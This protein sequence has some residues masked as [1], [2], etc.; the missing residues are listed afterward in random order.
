MAELTKVAGPPNAG[1]HAL[2]FHGLNGSTEATWKVA[3]GQGLW[4]SWFADEIEGLAVWAVGYSAAGSCWTGP[5]NM[6]LTELA[7]VLLQR[8]AHEKELEAGN[9][10]LVGY[11]LGGLVAKAVLRAAEDLKTDPYAGSLFQRVERVATIATPHFGS[12]WAGWQTR[13]SW[14]TR[15]TR[16]ARSLRLSDP[17]LVNLNRWFVNWAAGRADRTLAFREGLDHT[18]GRKIVA[19]ESANPGTVREIN[20][21]KD[22]TT[23]VHVADRTDIVYL[24]L[25]RFL[26]EMVASRLKVAPAS[27]QANEAR[28]E[29]LFGKLDENQTDVTRG[30]AQLRPSSSTASSQDAIA[31]IV[32]PP[33]P[34]G[35]VDAEIDRRLRR[36]RRGRFVPGYPREREARTLAEQLLRGELSGGGVSARRDALAWVAR[37]LAHAE[38]EALASEAVKASEALGSSLP[39]ALALAFLAALHDRAEGIALAAAQAG[40]IARSATLFIAS[41][42]RSPAESLAWFEA[43]GIT[44]DE[45]DVEGKVVLLGLLLQDHRWEAAR[46]LALQAEASAEDAP[47][48]LQLAALARFT[49]TLPLELRE[50]SVQIP[51][52]PRTLPLASDDAAMADRRAAVHL[53]DAFRAA[54]ADLDCQAAGHLAEDVALWLRLRDP[55]T[56]AAA[57]DELR[58]STRDPDLTLRRFS[59]LLDY[60]V[61]MDLPLVEQAIEREETLT[62]GA[63]PTAAAARFAFAF[64]H[65][66]PSAAAAYLRKHWEQLT[67]HLSPGALAATEVELLARAGESEEAAARLS[68]IPADAL[69]PEVLARAK[70]VVSNDLIAQEGV[71]GARARYEAHGTIPALMSLIDAQMEARDW[72]GVRDSSADLLQRTGDAGAL[73]KLVRALNQLSDYAGVDGALRA[74][75]ELRAYS[76]ELQMHWAWSLFRAGELEKAREAL[77]AAGAEDADTLAL[78]INLAI[79]SGRWGELHEMVERIYESRA[80]QP[81]ERLIQAAQLANTLGSDRAPALAAEAAERSWDNAGILLGAYS[82]AVSSGRENAPEVGRLFARAAELSGGNGPVQAISLEELLERQPEWNAHQSSVFE[83]VRAGELPLF[84]AAQA[85]NSTLIQ[86]ILVT[87]LANFDESD[88]R[89]RPLISLRAGV[90]KPLPPSLARVALDPSTLLAW[91]LA[92]VFSEVLAAFE[93]VVLPHDTLA[94]LFEERRRLPFHQPSRVRE[95][96]KIRDLVAEG[97][98]KVFAESAALPDHLAAEVGLELATLMAEARSTGG[99]VIRGP[100]IHRP[101]SLGGETGDVSGYEDLFRTGGDLIDT[102]RARGV[103]SAEETSRA[104]SYFARQEADVWPHRDIPAGATLFLDG[105]MLGYLHHAGV[106]DRL[107]SAGF[108]VM[109]AE[110]ALAEHNALLAYA[111]RA[112]EVEALLMEAR[113][114]L[115]AGLRD[116]AISLGPAFRGNLDDDEGEIGFDHPSRQLFD[117]GTRVEVVVADDRS[118]N[119]F[120]NVEAKGRMTPVISTFELMQGLVAAGRMDPAIRW[121][122]LAR[123]RRCN[124]MFLPIEPD[125]I[126]R[127][128]KGTTDVSEGLLVETLELRALRENF[129]SAAAGRLLQ[130][131]GEEHWLLSA[132]QAIREAMRRQWDD[133]VPDELAAARTEWLLGLHDL[134]AWSHRLAGDFDG[135]R[136]FS[137]YVQPLLL[138]ITCVERLPAAER[139]QRWVNEKLLPRLLETEPKLYRALTAAA[140]KLVESRLVATETDD[141]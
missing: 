83:R 112:D 2:F 61:D 54:I 68:A 90:A 56:A 55:R 13:L 98:L 101:G 66:T 114:A 45:L 96:Q 129:Q 42:D 97:A 62:Q 69:E 137:L 81:P 104:K 8:I 88:G 23:I 111:R 108:V 49:W 65:E 24:G 35:L 63:S 136:V 123:L 44:S 39:G 32:T 52:R 11:S 7:D 75:P 113:G 19:P 103:L 74:H 59:L 126:D 22:H 110:A 26:R 78:R 140:E 100:P 76:P 25:E 139:Y 12:E 99:L 82:I 93:H 72:A 14:I 1:A 79:A 107:A 131:P 20:T 80:S 64:T 60:G 4:P 120:A 95:A 89:A 121:R 132:M 40:P 67:R 30:G 91:L 16:L 31:R 47:Q 58:A 29:R 48:F 57:L 117:L 38:T 119:R 106:L 92:G 84:A 85:L 77:T 43:S 122:A 51:M 73:L 135:E 46:T 86:M 34:S 50:A 33:V 17:V 116:G 71:E 124:V 6:P 115:E 3:G 10:A 87:G 118:M 130:V 133:E 27:L 37:I 94:W 109:V 36:L 125:E 128:I 53:L 134:R 9:V 18:A 28:R 127:L 70:A 5:Q 138:A 41:R 21:D 105:L 141:G 15:P 102:L